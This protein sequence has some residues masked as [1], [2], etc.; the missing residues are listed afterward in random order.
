MV[1]LAAEVPPSST[2]SRG[3]EVE[4]GVRRDQ[5]HH[6]CR[7]SWPVGVV[8]EERRR[9][10]TSWT[11]TATRRAESPASRNP[12]AT[13][14][15]RRQA[16][17]RR[18]QQC[19]RQTREA[20][21]AGLMR[22]L[23][24]SCVRAASSAHLVV[25][26]DVRRH[27]VH[28]RRSGAAAARAPGPRRSTSARSRRGRDD[29]EREDHAALT[30]IA[31]A[32]DARQ[33]ARASADHRSDRSRLRRDHVVVAEDVEHRERRA[34]GERISGVRLPPVRHDLRVGGGERPPGLRALVLRAGSRGRRLRRGRSATPST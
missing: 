31:D 34:A 22:G 16:R 10:S 5:L 30:E 14:W 27:Q 21:P 8:R 25:G 7:D 1:E 18:R 29:F 6:R 32:R 24:S 33:G 23:R 2:G 28:G 11:T 13:P 9:L 15:Q 20:R 12:R 26:D 17:S 3:R 19:R 4:R